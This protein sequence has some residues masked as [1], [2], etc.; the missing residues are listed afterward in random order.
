MKTLSLSI[1]KKLK[2]YYR[3]KSKQCFCCN[4]ASEFIFCTFCQNGLT[5]NLIHCDLCKLP[6]ATPLSL[7]GGCQ[8]SLPDY[9]KL[10][11]PF[12]YLGLIKALIKKLKFKQATYN[13]Q[14]L[15]ELLAP[16]L[17]HYYLI[18]ENN[19]WPETLIYVPSHP[20]RIRERGFCH[21]ALLAKTLIKILPAPIRLQKN[22]LI[23]QHH[24]PAQHKKS[25]KQRQKMPN[26]TFAVHTTL[27]QHIALLDDVMTT[28]T[29]INTVVKTLKKSAIQKVDVWCFA[30]T[31][32]IEQQ[33]SR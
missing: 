25:K 11:A 14:T 28:G 3:A 27:P 13:A 17:I 22:A 20:K 6:T 26:D 29:T 12:L 21:M 30:R 8:M 19:V 18:N 23:K 2:V 15:C 7:C 10:L 5:E 33:K 16:K 31:P 1:T 4:Q 9:R 24:Q 32:F